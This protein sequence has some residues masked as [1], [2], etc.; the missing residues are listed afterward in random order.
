MDRDF[1]VPQP[2]STPHGTVA[3]FDETWTVDPRE[4][5][6]FFQAE[7][8]YWTADRTIEQW[9]RLLACSR[10]LTARLVPEGH[11]GGRLVGAT[12]LWSDHAYEAKLYDVVT[13]RDL[14]REGIASELVKWALRHPWVG[15]VQRF[16]LETR[17]AA[18]FYPRFGFR[19]GP[20]V[21]SFH[22]RVATHDLQTRG[23]R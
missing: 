13:A 9:R 19:A 10:L 2:L 5:Q 7:E 4:L 21:D 12:R 18:D 1:F 23:L 15:E 14:M 22:M 17:D 6:I 11:R 8:V 3:F 16:V 20:D